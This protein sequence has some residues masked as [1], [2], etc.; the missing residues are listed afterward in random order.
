M[1][2]NEP[3][4]Q[5]AVNSNLQ[6]RPPVV[7]VLGHVDHGKSSLLEAIREDFVI[8]AKESGGITQHIGAYAVDIKGKKITFID[9]PGHEAFSAIRQRGA[10]VADIAL[11]V[12]DAVE[13]IKMQTREAMK[14]IKEAG[15]P[16]VVV[17][18]KIDKPGAD[19]EKVKGQLAKED[20]LVETYGGKIPSCNVS[21]KTKQGIPELLETILLVAE[22]EELQADFSARAEGVILESSMDPQRGPVA[23]L[24]LNQG[25]LRAGD[26]L[27]TH[28]SFAKIKGIFDFKG[29]AIETAQPSQP[30]AVLGFL[31]PPGVGEKFKAYASLEEA[32]GAMKR[33]E[34]V[35]PTFVHVADGVKVLNIILKSDFLGS[36]EAVEN[37]LKN[38]PHDKVVLRVLKSE[39]GQVSAEDIKLAESGLARVFCFH[40]KASEDIESF[41]R[42][43]NVKIKTFDVIY[44]LVQEVRR[45]MTQSMALETTRVEL[46]KFKITHLFKADKIEQIVGGKV[47]EGEFTKGVRADIIREEEVIGQAK[48]R[49]IQKD[50]KDIGK[51]TKG[52]E[53][54]IS[55]VSDIILDQNDIL[56]IYREDK[57]KGTL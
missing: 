30:V 14:F 45:E 21:A 56:K 40:V 47:Q 19:P 39:V 55:V 4:K 26:I 12:V 10:K 22:M 2:E 25:T 48:I 15:V 13:G 28:F 38:I 52:Q 36:K 3:N 51:A 6:T 20:I 29:K 53:I 50:K 57:T 34:R 33:E 23:T 9:T 35:S 41:A 16:L 8:C 54:G 1:A 42:Q 24:I 49:G 37:I 44:E 27:A 31:E 5:P 32:N 7:V 11:L 43:R 46:A 17:F 18:N